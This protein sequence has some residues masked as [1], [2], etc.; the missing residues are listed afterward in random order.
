MLYMVKRIHFSPLLRI[1]LKINIL[2][3]IV[4]VVILTLF[5]LVIEFVYIFRYLDTSHINV[6]V[7]VNY[8]RVVVKG[9]IF[10]IALNDEVK[11]S[12][13]VVQRSQI[14]GQLVV[15]VPKLNENKLLSLNAEGKLF[16]VLKM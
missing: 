2:F 7:E 4:R 11:P 13:A 5:F 10:Q 8:I 6:N 14:T 16:V 12:E 9:K 1:I 15:T 3:Y